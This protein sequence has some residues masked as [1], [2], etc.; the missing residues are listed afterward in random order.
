[1]PIAH[2]MFNEMNE[3]VDGEYEI[4]FQEWRMDPLGLTCALRGMQNLLEDFFINPKFVKALMEFLKKARIE[5]VK[6]QTK[7]LRKKIGK[8]DLDNDEVNT[9][10]ISPQ[11][12]EEFILPFERE[13][14]SFHCGIGYWYSCGDISKLLPWIRKIPVIDMLHVGPWTKLNRVKDIFGGDTPLEI[15]LMPTS[16]ILLATVEQMEQ[17]L[18]EIKKILLGTAFTVR[19]DALQVINSVNTDINKI[20][21]WT[22]IAYEIFTTEE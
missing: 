3:L 4:V 10:T 22:K 19:A 7:F 16:D 8:C 18:N 1:M 15:C 17:K 12:Y 20:K 13:I 6:E 21:K 5:W 9:P 2:Q 11:I 14:C